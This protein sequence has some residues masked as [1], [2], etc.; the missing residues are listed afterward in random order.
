MGLG[1][2][3]CVCRFTNVMAASN[4]RYRRQQRTLHSLAHLL[5]GSNEIE[6]LKSFSSDAVVMEM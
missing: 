3:V 6:V 4:R 2:S 5:Y 1:L